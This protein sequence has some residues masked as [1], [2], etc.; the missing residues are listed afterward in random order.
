MDDCDLYPGFV[1]RNGRVLIYKKGE[2]VILEN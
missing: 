1:F 2:R